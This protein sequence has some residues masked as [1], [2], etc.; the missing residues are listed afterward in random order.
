MAVR[1]SVP[2]RGLLGWLCISPITV[3]VADPPAHAEAIGA[4]AGRTE[5]A[6]TARP[7]ELSARPACLGDGRFPDRLSQT[8]CYADLTKRAIAPGLHYYDVSSPL[9][10]DGAHK[11]RWLALPPGGRVRVHASGR[12]DFPVGSVLVK[13]FAFD[14]VEGQPA[15]RRAIE[16]RLMRLGPNGWDFRSYRWNDQGTDAVRLEATQHVILA[17]QKAAPA[18][19]GAAMSATKPAGSESL[20]LIPS[21]RECAYC[22]SEAAG[23]VLGPHSAQMDLLVEVAGKRVNQLDHLA[24]RGVFEPTSRV[25]LPPGRVLPDPADPK[26]PLERRARSYLHAQCAHC[27]TPGGWAPPGLTLDLRYDRTLAETATCGVYTQYFTQEPRIQAGDP[28]ASVI[29]RR[30]KVTNIHRMPPMGT[31]L[32]DPASL[33][34]R[35]WIAS[36]DRCPTPRL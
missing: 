17:V 16:T 30:M 25:H 3:A 31:N 14:P 36:L 27:H 8:G 5:S 21:P 29:W 28:N 20:H 23:L 15:S 24:S 10:T 33:V 18:L 22:H 19:A 2:A 35:D 32:I 4:S 11:R 12:W 26:I 13:E 1:S 7:G 34:V 6:G 9:W